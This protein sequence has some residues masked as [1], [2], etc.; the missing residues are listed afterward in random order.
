MFLGFADMAERMPSDLAFTAFADEE[1]PPGVLRPFL[2]RLSRI[3]G[4]I[5]VRRVI[6]DLARMADVTCR[7][8]PKAL[9]RF[10]PDAMII[11]QTDSASSL[12]ARALG[13]PSANVANALPLNREDGVP[14]P[15]LSWP[16]DPSAKGVRRNRGGY[17]VARLIEWPITRAIR[18]NA[19]RLGQPGVRFAQDA[20][21]DRCQ[22]TQCVR[23]LD[24]PRSALPTSFHYTGP[25]R[26]ADA[27]LDFELPDSRPVV[28]CSL[29]TL[30]GSRQQIFRDVATAAQR[31]NI[32]LVIAHGGLLPEREAAR[33]PGDPIV[34]DFVP[35]RAL[36]ARSALAVT[37][38]GFNT[39]LDALSFGVPM[40]ALPLA[41]E[42]PATGARLSRIGAA[43]VLQRRRT[44]A[45]IEE[46][47]AKVLRDASY[48]DAAA[49]LAGE[50]AG[51]GGAARAADLI[52]GSLGL[53]ARLE[54][55]TTAHED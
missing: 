42:Q 52:E 31:L 46:A 12:V 27:R 5:S 41:F 8:L 47:M 45:S 9:E 28:F 6:G 44:A 11:D 24:F 18:R 38:A 50:I 26:E 53:S 25:F 55:A 13:I 23:G 29:G 22:V 49:K 2:N 21:S 35:Q 19:A 14:P 1:M 4:I 7:L 10:S 54:A 40:V 33:L 16:Y 43:E 20:W 36:L 17:R 37:H 48:R 32:Q 34:R 15:V 30:Q 39:V 3:G 51:S